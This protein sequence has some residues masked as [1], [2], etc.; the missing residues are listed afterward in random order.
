MTK[1]AHFNA[2]R[3]RVTPFDIAADLHDSLARLRTDYVDVYLLHRDD[4][5]VDVGPIVEALNEH[6]CAGRIRAFGGSNW[7]HQRIAEANRYAETHGLVGFA[8]SSPQFSLVEQVEAPWPGCVSISGPQGAEA[9]A[10]YERHGMPVFCWSSLARGFLSGQFTPEQIVAWPDDMEGELVRCFRCEA[11]L[12]RLT[13]A[14]RLAQ[15]K[16]APVAQIAL[17]YLLRQPLTVFPLVGAVSGEEYRQN[18]GA[19]EVALTP[20]EMDWLDLRTP[21]QARPKTMRA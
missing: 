15:E 18:A 10:W 2:D 17:A 4:P 9:R 8:A 1:G 3:N 7:S 12:A 20:Q 19:L 11:N 16:G 6:H 5:A 13:R 21:L 14:G